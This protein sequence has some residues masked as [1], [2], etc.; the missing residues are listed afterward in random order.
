MN[1]GSRTNELTLASLARPPFGEAAYHLSGTD[2]LRPSWSST[3]SAESVTRT[4]LAAAASI[5]GLE[6][7]MPRL[8]KRGPVSLHQ[9]RNLTQFILRESAVRRHPD[10]VEP[11]FRHLPSAGNVNV[12]RLGPVTRK[13]E[14]PVQDHFGEPWDSRRRFCQLCDQANTF[15]RSG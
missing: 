14:E 11:E 15:M 6:E 8:E 13:E 4:R 5:A 9:R 2:T 10:R 1:A 12:R 3:T 7:V